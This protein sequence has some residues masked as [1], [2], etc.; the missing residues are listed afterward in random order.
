MEYDDDGVFDDV[1][2]AKDAMM[3]NFGEF[4]VDEKDAE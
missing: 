4:Q 1:D 3:S 2:S